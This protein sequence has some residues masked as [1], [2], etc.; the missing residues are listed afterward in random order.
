MGR[1]TV[2]SEVESRYAGYEPVAVLP[3]LL[4]VNIVAVAHELAGLGALIDE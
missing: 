1:A 3:N 4:E 2:V